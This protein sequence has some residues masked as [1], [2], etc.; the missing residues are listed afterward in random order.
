MSP[1]RLLGKPYSYASD[2]WALG[3]SL[4]ALAIGRAP[5]AAKG[6]YWGVLQCVCH[7]EEEGASPAL[8]SLPAGTCVGLCCSGCLDVNIWMGDHVNDDDVVILF[9]PPFSPCSTSSFTHTDLPSPNLKHRRPM[10][11]PHA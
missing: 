1:E 2:I 9:T 11:P 6:G 8:A 3:L 4:L 10:V 5:L 7:K